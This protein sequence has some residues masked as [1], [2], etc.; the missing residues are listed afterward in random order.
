M[1]NTSWALF[2]TKF[3]VVHVRHHARMVQIRNPEST[4]LPRKNKLQ[5]ACE[6]FFLQ[7]FS[8]YMQTLKTHCLVNLLILSP[9]K[10]KKSSS[11]TFSNH[12][13]Q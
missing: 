1:T 9:K 6:V 12:E 5:I 2:H 13:G 10:K 8:I 3:Y 11:T 7:H 4:Y